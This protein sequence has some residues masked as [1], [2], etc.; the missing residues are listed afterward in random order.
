[1]H[2][3]QS[4]RKSENRAF[5]TSN[6]HRFEEALQIFLPLLRTG[7]IDF[8]GRYYQAQDCELRSADPDHRE[9]PAHARRA[10]TYASLWNAEGPL[11]QSEEITRCERQAMSSV[12]RWG[13]I[14]PSWAVVLPSRS[15]SHR[16]KTRAG[17]TRRH[18]VSSRSWPH[19][20]RSSKC[21]TVTREGLNHVQIWLSPS[22]IAGLEGLAAVLDLLDHSEAGFQA[23]KEGAQD[24]AWAAHL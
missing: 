9:G 20:T 3:Q 2:I 18:G 22:T 23:M 10:A 7:Q 13:A 21:P 12:P 16:H 19:L 8:E 1:L 14:P 24:E 5:G 4:K 11:R 6:D 15:I 17:S